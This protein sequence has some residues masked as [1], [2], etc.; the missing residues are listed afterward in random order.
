MFRSRSLIWYWP[1]PICICITLYFYM[2]MSGKEE[3]LT[4]CVT[5]IL[6]ANQPLVLAF[7]HQRAF[8]TFYP[9]LL[10]CQRPY[11]WAVMFPWVDQEHIF[12]GG[13]RYN[14]SILQL[15]CPKNI[16]NGLNLFSQEWTTCRLEQLNTTC[17][18]SFHLR[19]GVFSLPEPPVQLPK[20][21]LKPL[22]L[23]FLST[24]T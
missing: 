19:P 23:I 6:I 4:W 21:M 14:V 24:N 1:S 10:E 18:S 3:S 20:N 16:L 15:Q 2:I 17:R 13:W 9:T 11:I 7:I 8:I 5:S 12:A 22:K